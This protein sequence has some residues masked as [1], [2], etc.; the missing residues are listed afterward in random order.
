MKRIVALLLAVLMVFT[1]A[2][3]AGKTTCDICGEKKKC[4]TIEVLGQK[5]KICKDCQN[6]IADLA[7]GLF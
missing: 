6:E 1:L 2:A 5:V 7:G 3:C 4:D